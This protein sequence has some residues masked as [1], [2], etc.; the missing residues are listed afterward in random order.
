MIE[1]GMSRSWQGVARSATI[2]GLTQVHYQRCYYYLANWI[3]ET[4]GPSLGFFAD[5]LLQ[6]SY[7]G[8]GM[9]QRHETFKKY[10]KRATQ[11]KGTWRDDRKWNEQKLADLYNNFKDMFDLDAVS[12]RRRKYKLSEQQIWK[13]IYWKL[14]K[15]HRLVGEEK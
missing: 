11:I 12:I 14:K 4:A 5:M 8:G 13:M 1:S 15:N 3:S 9:F 6:S 7:Q 10:I 2:L